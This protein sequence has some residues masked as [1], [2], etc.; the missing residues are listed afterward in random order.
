MTYTSRNNDTLTLSRLAIE[1]EAHELYL[2]ATDNHNGY[3][4]G[5]N[6]KEAVDQYMQ[7][8][9]KFLRLGGL[10][11]AEKAMRFPGVAHDISQFESKILDA[12]PDWIKDGDTYSISAAKSELKWTK[13]DLLLFT[14]LVMQALTERVNAIL[15]N[16][17]EPV[18]LSAYTYREQGGL[19]KNLRVIS[20][21]VSTFEPPRKERSRLKS[22]VRKEAINALLDGDIKGMSCTLKINSAL[23]GN[24]I[25]PKW[26]ET[27]NW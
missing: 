21:T 9:P 13:K 24:Y 10:S 15:E 4:D 16:L 18:R 8:L 7:C 1:K 23:S 25:A 2:R 14:T 17:R 19:K 22:L 20:E 3:N 5:Y 26:E 27:L 6:A 11:Y 12:V